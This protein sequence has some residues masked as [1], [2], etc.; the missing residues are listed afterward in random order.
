MRMKLI[1]QYDSPFVRR[2]AIALRLHGLSYEHLPWS[3]FRDAERIA[4]YNPLLRVPTLVLA[5]G[6]V[7]T[8][9]HVIID[10]IE[11]IADRSLWPSDPA[12]FVRALRVTSLSTGSADK[13]VSLVY[14]ELLHDHVSQ[15]WIDRC[16]AQIVAAV[17]RLEAEIEPAAGP[18][19]FGDALGHAD[20]ALACMFRFLGE[21]HADRFDFQRWP[22][23]RRHSELCESQPLFAD[24][25]QPFSVT[26]PSRTG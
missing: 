1:G 5:D 21:A 20:I 23:L 19:L 15:Q 2:V 12:E 4:A 18:R 13:A 10:Y 6:E 26:L 16:E 25:A 3:V 9:S 11:R 17:D 22:S 14:E 8:E 24:V 7:L